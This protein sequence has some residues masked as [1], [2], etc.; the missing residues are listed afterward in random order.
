MKSD[1]HGNPPATHGPPDYNVRLF[2]AMGDGKTKETRAIQNAIDTCADNGGGRVVLPAGT[3]LSGTIWLKSHT[4]LH[5]AAGA[6]LLGSPDKADYNADDAFPENPVVAKES[7]SGGHLIIAYRQ[8]NIAITGHGTVDGNSLSFFGPLPAGA[9]ATYR[10][11]DARYP[12]PGWRPGQMVVFCRCA[13]VKVT[14]V[15][16]INSPFWTVLVYGCQ[17]VGI[18]GVKIENPPASRNSDG[19]SLDCSRRVTVSDCIIRSGDD[20]ITVRACSK[21][22]GEPPL[23][24][25]NIV[26]S[27]CVLST[28]CTAVRIGV[29]EGLIRKCRFDNIVVAEARTG[30]KVIS[31]YHRYSDYLKTSPVGDPDKPGARIEQVHFSNFTMDCILPVLVA[32]GATA[33]PPADIRDITFSNFHITASAASQMIGRSDLPPLRGI[34]W[35]NIDLHIHGGTDNTEFAAAFPAPETINEQGGYLGL[36]DKPALPCAVYGSGLRECRFENF[37]V[38]WENPAKVW[39]YGFFIERSAETIFANVALRQ[40]GRDAGACALRFRECDGLLLS[41]CRAA[42]GTIVFARIEDSMPGSRVRS[43]GN[44]FSFAEQAVESDV[45]VREAGNLYSG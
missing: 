9:S 26:V 23:P 2:G 43:A 18:S 21:R 6:T 37:R 29:G 36:N 32:H 7:S 8:E 4:E 40:P 24:C 31:K 14:D 38:H 34:V 19:L 16:F 42:P 45:D 25:E 35:S 41:G 15:R 17:D 13:R 30:I 44:D 27:N 20:S 5:L 3:Y 33:A 12:I 11:R 1:S 10:H 39:R 28:P 22:L